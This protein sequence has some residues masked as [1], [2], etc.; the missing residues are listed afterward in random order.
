[1]LEVGEPDDARDPVR[2]AEL[3]GDLETLDAEH[4][5][6]ATGQVIQRRAPH[7]ADAD[8]DHVVALH[9]A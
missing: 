6:A 7:A 2:G 4:A 5:L 3:V 8:D 1:M 9:P